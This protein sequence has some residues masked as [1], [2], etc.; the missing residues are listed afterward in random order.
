MK[1]NIFNSAYLLIKQID[2]HDQFVCKF[3]WNEQTFTLEFRYLVGRPIYVFT[4]FCW[5]YTNLNKNT[6]PI[7]AH[8]LTE[9]QNDFKFNVLNL[10]KGISTFPK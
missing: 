1:V 2:D 4:S 6:S 3:Y 7:L 10:I 9:I 8:F 5:E